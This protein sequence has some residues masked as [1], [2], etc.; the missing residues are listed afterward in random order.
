M[1]TSS[2]Q[3]Y[4]WDPVEVELQ[5]ILETQKDLVST[6]VSTKTIIKKNSIGG[7]YLTS[8]AYCINGVHL[9]TGGKYPYV[10]I[11]NLA[12]QLIVD[13]IKIT[14]E[15]KENSASDQFNKKSKQNGKA[16][17]TTH[18]TT[19]NLLTKSLSMSPL[20][21]SWCVATNSGVFL[22]EFNNF[23]QKNFKSFENVNLDKDSNI[24]KEGFKA[25]SISHLLLLNKVSLLSQC[26]VITS[27]HDISKVSKDIPTPMV[28]KLLI[29]LSELAYSS[30][31]FEYFLNWFYWLLKNHTLKLQTISLNLL[32]LSI[33]FIQ[34]KLKQ[35]DT[36]F[37]ELCE[38]NEFLLDYFSNRIY[39][40]KPKF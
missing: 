38:D 35:N 8:L 1:G 5:N 34:N 36:I 2:G 16:L 19:L 13:K 12:Y 26:I 28:P 30:P 22:S 14:E 10:L 29:Q 9:L 23:S 24:T 6:I 40:R 33:R 18:D 39:V 7:I 37:C 15:K 20:G 4:L 31:H 21:Q 25:C 27:L 11:Y 32:S 3:I 17:I